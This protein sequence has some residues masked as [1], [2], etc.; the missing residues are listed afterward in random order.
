MG[1]FKRV[2]DSTDDLSGNPLEW[3]QAQLAHWRFMADTC[4][5]IRA[6]GREREHRRKAKR[7]ERAIR[8]KAARSGLEAQPDSDEFHHG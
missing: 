6:R 7:I 3:L 2:K 1:R 5:L 4:A 8:Q